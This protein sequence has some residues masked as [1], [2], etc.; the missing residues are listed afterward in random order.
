MRGDNPHL[1]NI[2]VATHACI[3]CSSEQALLLSAVGPRVRSIPYLQICQSVH[4]L[5]QLLQAH[6]HPLIR[7]PL[8][9]SPL[10]PP[11]LP[12]RHL[13]TLPPSPSSPPLHCGPSFHPPLGVTPA[14]AT[15]TA[16]ATACACAPSEDR[17][18]A[19]ALRRRQGRLRGLAVGRKGR[20]GQTCGS[21]GSTCG[22]GRRSTCSSRS[23]S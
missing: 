10:L 7:R 17:G 13:S 4:L 21:S 15:A 6:L 8:L 16:T 23:G 12:L 22:S 18:W 1:R 11:P 20:S 3:C 5:L 9:S 14:T 2:R 19:S